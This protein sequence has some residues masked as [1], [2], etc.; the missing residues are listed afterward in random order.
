MGERPD[1]E[2]N[3]SGGE[4]GEGSEEGTNNDPLTKTDVEAPRKSFGSG[5]ESTE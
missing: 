3:E 2:Q 5:P 4:A 1:D